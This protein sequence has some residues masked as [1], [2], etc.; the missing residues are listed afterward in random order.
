MSG[1]KPARYK[2]GSLYAGNQQ[3]A[4]N[5]T[6]R[7]CGKCNQHSAPAGFRLVRP[8]G[9][10]GPCCQKPRDGGKLDNV[11]ADRLAPERGSE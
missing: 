5:G 2:D 8:W 10:V 7:S 11:R 6:M 4:G 1:A 3:Y 9:M